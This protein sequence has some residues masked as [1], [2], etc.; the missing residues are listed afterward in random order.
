VKHTSSDDT[1]TLKGEVIQT[2]TSTDKFGR[3]IKL[4]PQVIADAWKYIEETMAVTPI[5]GG[6]LPTKE[7]LALKL[8]VTR[9]TMDN[10]SEQSPDF[11]DIVKTL[12]KNQ[13]D[14]LIQY[15]LIGKYNPM[16]TKLL[17]SKHG[18]VE[19]QEIDQNVNVVQP[20]IGGMAKAELPEGDDSSNSAV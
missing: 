15:S 18:Y 20:I 5:A 4:T 6:L 10:W 12:E 16:I 9:Q 2:I 14:R 3:P 19:K 8:K 1:K 7:G 17:L 11:L 13:A